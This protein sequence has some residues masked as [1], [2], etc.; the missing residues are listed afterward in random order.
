MKN[1]TGLN[2]QNREDIMG[3]IEEY[4][5]QNFE[6]IRMKDREDKGGA[7][8]RYH[9]DINEESMYLD[10]YFINN[11]KTTIKPD[12]GKNIEIKEKIAEYIK[13]ELGSEISSKSSVT[14]KKI[15]KEDFSIFIGLISESK[16]IIKA[17]TVEAHQSDTKDTSYDIIGTQ[18][19]SVKITY[20]KNG[21][22]L[23]QG[24]PLRLF[25]ELT[26]ILSELFLESNEMINVLNRTYKVSVE[27][28]SVEDE[29]L[30]IMHSCKDKL[31][32]KMKIVI[33]Q[34]IY[35]TK[36][37]GEMF[38]YTFL[39]QPA[40]RALEGNI[41]YVAEENG[42]PWRANIGDL[43]DHVN[44]HSLIVPDGVVINETVVDYLEKQYRDFRDE[45]NAY[46][47]WG[48]KIGNMDNTS[49]IYKRESA[50]TKI[51]DILKNINYYHSIC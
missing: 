21:T 9:F 30:S 24:R 33:K 49:L 6:N 44:G 5:I 43:F 51:L 38:D 20:Y 12:S 37:E 32:E 35:N 29:F 42:L 39:V 46:S 17:L 31:S 26:S 34:A 48:R 2:I 10:F 25:G 19:D 27:K 41:K 50:I 18:G 7:L 47:H 11:G 23:M 45:R 15:K 28:E 22:I 3:C 14:V 16:E 13:R 8:F 4:L 1:F 40:F 36:I